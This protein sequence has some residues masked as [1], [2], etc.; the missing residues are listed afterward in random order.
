MYGGR[1]SWKRMELEEALAHVARLPRAFGTKEINHDTQR[2]Y[3]S[4]VNSSRVG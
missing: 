1:W 3:I 2:E 4:K